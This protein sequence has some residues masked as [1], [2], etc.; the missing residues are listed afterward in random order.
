[1]SMNE[2]TT[3]VP[4]KKNRGNPESLAKARAARA[5]KIAAEKAKPKDDL[6][7]LMGKRHEPA[8]QFEGLS[9]RSCCDA[10]SNGTCIISGDEFCAS[11]VIGLQPKHAMMPKV[12]AR[13]RQ[14]L[15]YLEQLK[16]AHRVSQ[17]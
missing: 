14:A 9:G 7:K 10:C 12:V 5:A 8:N 4:V 6:G 11:P 15:L 2:Q 3:A 16:T 1:M 17:R 13:R